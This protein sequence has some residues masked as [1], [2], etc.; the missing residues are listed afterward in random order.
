[1]LLVNSKIFP[2]PGIV[3][4]PER[5]FLSGSERIRTSI[6]KGFLEKEKCTAK[7]S[8]FHLL[9]TAIDLVYALCSIRN[10]T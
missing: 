9:K 10:A 1:M 7:H 5:G 8:H 3:T 4:F 6:A 2:L